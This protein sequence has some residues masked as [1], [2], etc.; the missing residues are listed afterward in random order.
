LR[1]FCYT[2]TDIPR[3]AAWAMPGLNVLQRVFLRVGHG[4]AALVRTAGGEL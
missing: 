2:P 3:V 1:E 4:A